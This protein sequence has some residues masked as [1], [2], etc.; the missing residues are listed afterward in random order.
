MSQKFQTAQ[1]SGDAGDLVVL[2]DAN[3]FTQYLNGSIT[4]ID[5]ILEAAGADTSN[6][7]EALYDDYLY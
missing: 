2:S 1:V 6:Y 3:W 5:P 7:V 4:P